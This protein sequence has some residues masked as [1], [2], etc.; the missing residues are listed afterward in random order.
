MLVN[1]QLP[2][3]SG[4]NR[5]SQPPQHD[6][7]LRD[8]E[9][10]WLQSWIQQSAPSSDPAPAKA[11]SGLSSDPQTAAS[12]VGPRDVGG[13]VDASSLDRKPVVVGGEHSGMAGVQVVVDRPDFLAGQ[14]LEQDLAKRS[15]TPELAQRSARDP[16]ATALGPSPAAEPAH[17][18]LLRLPPAAQSLRPG[19]VKPQEAAL[20]SRATAPA[21]SQAVPQPGAL[22]WREPQQGCIQ[23][24]LCAPWMGE[25]ASRQAADSLAFA[26]MQ[27]GYQRAQ[28]YVNGNRQVRQ[29]EAEA[30][31]VSSPPVARSAR[32]AQITS[33]NP[34]PESPHGH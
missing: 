5:S 1:A 3:S 13:Q 11:Q 26:L 15:A 18:P 31:T 32:P 27:A 30:D 7:W 24:S 28:V 14:D 33:Q 17:L 6:Q 25:L 10:A 20:A 29:R 12:N 19:S 22:H 4:P 9:R 23:A 16:S 2:E 21:P 8:M 34:V